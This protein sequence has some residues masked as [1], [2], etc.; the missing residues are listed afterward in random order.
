MH[1]RDRRSRG[2]ARCLAPRS[3]GHVCPRVS[4]LE[5]PSIRVLVVDNN[6]VFR[7]GLSSVLEEAGD[8]QVAGEVADG[9]DALR[10]V[11][12]VDPHVVLLN[13]LMPVIDGLQIA[14]LLAKRTRVLMLTHSHEQDLV[15]DA[16]SAGSTDDIVVGQFDLDELAR[17][18]RRLASP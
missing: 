2:P 3:D 8:I 14:R 7:R 17:R 18:I 6:A 5:Q 9:L 12:E 15:V 13:V 1:R 11:D 16:L 10:V 4:G